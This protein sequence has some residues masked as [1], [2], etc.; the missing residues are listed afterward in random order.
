MNYQEKV[1]TRADERALYQKEIANP[2]IRCY[3]G[4]TDTKSYGWDALR[5]DYIKK[6]GEVFFENPSYDALRVIVQE[7]NRDLEPLVEE[8][9]ADETKGDEM[10]AQEGEHAPEQ[11]MQ[12]GDA[13][14]VFELE[15]QLSLA[16]SERDEARRAQLELRDALALVASLAAAQ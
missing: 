7:E 1:R 4:Y 16:L 2:A 12:A 14:R 6:S 3:R 11:E 10:C 15:T 5:D 8:E 13:A 9:S